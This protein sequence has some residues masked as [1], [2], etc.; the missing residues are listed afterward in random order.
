[1]RLFGYLKAHR[2]IGLVTKTVEIEASHKLN[3]AVTQRLNPSLSNE[4]RSTVLNLCWDRMHELL[5][6]LAMV[7]VT[8]KS[9]LAERL[10][11][12]VTMYGKLLGAARQTAGSKVRS[13]VKSRLTTVPP[14]L[15]GIASN[16]YARQFLVDRTQLRRLLGK[17]PSLND[18]TIL[19]EA[20]CLTEVYNKIEA[21]TMFLASTDLLFSPMLNEDGT[22]KS[23]I[24]TVE[25][26]QR[27]SVECDWPHRISQRLE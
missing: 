14:Y 6:C 20:A 9:R 13:H 4:I 8:N 16:I 1:M 17:S 15:R 11:D 2:E 23:D 24:I 22:V 7:D 5:G 18:Q 3:S 12:V 19:A 25:I 26:R 27:F 10:G 21:T